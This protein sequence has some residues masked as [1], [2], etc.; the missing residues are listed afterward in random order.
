MGLTS[1]SAGPLSRAAADA[2]SSGAFLL[3]FGLGHRRFWVRDRLDFVNLP[4]I[5]AL[6]LVATRNDG[7][8]LTVALGTFEYC[9]V[10]ITHWFWSNE[11]SRTLWLGSKNRHASPL[12]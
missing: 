9:P 7:C 5:G 1:S 11:E 6:G 10:W 12:R 8:S 3:G 4:T 2:R